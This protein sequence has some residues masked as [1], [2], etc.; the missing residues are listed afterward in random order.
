MQVMI[1]VLSDGRAELATPSEMDAIDAFNAEVRAAGQWVFAAGLA[2]PTEST[3]IDNRD[4][5][6]LVVD[7]PFAES[8]EWIAGLWIFEVPDLQTARELA[9]AGSM[10]CNRKVELRPLLGAA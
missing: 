10:A 8:R 4:G 9:A 7:G 5:S 3:V 2:S 6:A 1:S